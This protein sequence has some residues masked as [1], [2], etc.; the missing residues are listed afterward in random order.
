MVNNDL[1]IIADYSFG[2]ELSEAKE[3]FLQKSS[4]SIE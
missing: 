4:L 1:G 2:E 3:D